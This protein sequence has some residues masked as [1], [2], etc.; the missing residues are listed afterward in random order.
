VAK[1]GYKALMNG[2]SKIISGFKNKVQAVI[3]NVLP[4]KKLASTMREQLS[5]S[6]KAKGRENITHP[7]SKEERERIEQTTGNK[8]GDYQSKY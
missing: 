5:P 3:S 8:E 4:D 6:H 7:A 2:E 1:D